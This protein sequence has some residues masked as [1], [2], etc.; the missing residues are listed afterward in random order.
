MALA[1]ASTEP[2]TSPLTTSGN[3]IAWSALE[4]EHVLE[5]DRGR[6]GALPVE[7]ALAV[8]G[9]LA[10]AGLVLDHRQRVAGR[11]HAGQAEHLDRDATDPLPS[12]ACPCRRS[13]P[14]PCPHRRRPRTCRRP[15]GCRAGRA[16][17]R[18]GRG[19]CRAWPRPPR[20]RRSGPDW[21][22]IRAFRPG[23]RSLR[24]SLSRL[25]FLSAE[26]STSWTSPPMSSTTIS[27]W[28]SSSRTFWALAPGLS[29][30]LIATIIGTPAALVWLIASIVCGF[31]P[32]S[33]ATTRTTMSVTLAP[34]GAHLGEGL[35]ARRIEE[36]DLRLVGQAHLIG[37]DMLGD[38]AGLAGDDV[39]AADRVEQAG[40]AVIDMAHDR[41]HRRTRLQGLGGIDVGAGLDVDVAFADP[42]LCGGR[43]PRPEAPPC[44]G[45]SS[46]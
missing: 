7:H 8:G 36:G 27:C 46:R 37:A 16:R 5:V 25:V 1:I 10:G 34:R 45:R 9:D 22:S 18:A 20:L 26:T 13:S 43:I 15:S 32:S 12:P 40:L 14:G 4:R 24:A 29:I 19:P 31:R 44:P 33:A 2:C 28:R 11:R 35:V 38:P 30:L 23:A 41:H 17:W 39:G 42:D 6:G 21:P 3:S